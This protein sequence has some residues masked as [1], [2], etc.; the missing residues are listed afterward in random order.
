MKKLAVLVTICLIVG[1][2]YVVTQPKPT[3]VPPQAPQ[4]PKVTYQQDPTLVNY[5]HQL[6]IDVS[7][8]NL[9]YD[10][11]KVNFTPN[12][13]T[14]DAAFYAPNTLVIRPGSNNELK[15]VAHEY[16]HYQWSLGNKA[17]PNL[18]MQV[19][20][21]NAAFRQ[22]MYP[23]TSLGVGSEAFLNELNS[24]ECTEYLDS[25]LPVN[26][27]NYCKQYLPNRNILPSLFR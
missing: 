2:A 25:S 4:A 26:L 15:S 19:Y 17:D 5:A 9:K 3:F 21:S 22:R 23:Y 1:W 27:L 7:Q 10:Q 18:L 12:G 14:V 13:G 8:L 24:I 6:G 16:L 20:N 11:P